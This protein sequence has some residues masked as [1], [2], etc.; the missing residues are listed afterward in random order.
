M[1]KNVVITGAAKGIGL[2]CAKK[3]R[4][5]GYFCYLLD[6][7]PEVLKVAQDLECQAYVVDIADYEAVA[8]VFAKIDT[9]ITVL[10]NNAGIQFVSSFADIK[11]SEWQ[12]VI[13][14]NLNGTF[15]VTKEAVKKMDNGTIVNVS[16]VHGENPRTEKYSYDASK[17][18]LN[19]MTKEFALALAPKIRVN[20]IAIGATMTPMNNGFLT[21]P[22]TK[23][24]AMEKVPLKV[25]LEAS[26]VAN[27]IFQMTTDNFKH[28]TGTILNYDGGRSLK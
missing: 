22:E 9:K 11:I 28:L 6:I 3:F 18:A 19:M 2:E 23:I 1:L 27:V 12:R 14:T 10:V 20:A 8:K 7:D 21:N 25:I 13:D 17:A 4:S 26:E 16:S 15:Y 24:A 5:E